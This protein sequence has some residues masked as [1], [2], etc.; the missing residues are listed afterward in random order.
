ML[1]T[2]TSFISLMKWK[3]YIF[4]SSLDGMKAICPKQFKWLYILPEF[5]LK[6]KTII[7]GGTCVWANVVF[8]NVSVISQW[9]LVVTGSSILTFIVLPHCG[10]K[11]KTSKHVPW[12]TNYVADN[13]SHFQFQEAK[14]WLDRDQ[15]TLPTAFLHF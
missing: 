12:K 10:I 9:F 11:F 1:L 8:Y 14:Q 5:L 3:L 7:P 2:N 15:C 13:L 4:S 6:N